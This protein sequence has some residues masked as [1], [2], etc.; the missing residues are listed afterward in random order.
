[1]LKL[2]YDECASNPCKHGA[3]CENKLTSYKCTC[4]P[5]YTGVNCEIEIDYCV[6]S[7]CI[8]GGS[9]HN[10]KTI[11]GWSCICPAAFGG[12]NCSIVIDQCHSNPCKN[13]ATCVDGDNAYTCQCLPGFTGVNCQT[14]INECENVTCKHGV[15]KDLVNKFECECNNNYF[16]KF[17]ET[18]IACP[19]IIPTVANSTTNITGYDLGDTVTYHCVSGYKFKDMAKNKTIKCDPTNKWIGLTSDMVCE[20][21]CSS[22]PRINYTDIDT[23]YTRFGTVANYTCK[24][25]Y[26]FP[27]NI[28]T[29]NTTC[30]LSGNWSRTEVDIPKC[31]VVKCPKLPNHS[32]QQKTNE[33]STDFNTTVVFWCDI[34]YTLHD[35][36]TARTIKCQENGKWTADLPPCEPVRCLDLGDIKNGQ[37]NSTATVYGSYIHYQCGKNSDNKQLRMLDGATYKIIKCDATWEWSDNVTDCELERCY[38]LPFVANA[39]PSDLN[40]TWGHS[41]ELTCDKGHSFSTTGIVSKKKTT[42]KQS[43]KWR[44]ILPSCVA[45]KCGE[46]M[47]VKNAKPDTDKRLYGTILTYNCIKGHEFGDKL[48]AKTIECIADKSWNRTTDQYLLQGCV[49]KKCT[50]PPQITNGTGPTDSN[51]RVYGDVLN[52]VCSSGFKFIDGE[53]KRNLLCDE[54]GNWNETDLSCRKDRCD[55]V[56]FFDNTITDTKNT[57][58]YTNVTYRCVEG[59]EWPINKSYHIIFCDNDGKWKHRSPQPLTHC[60]PK[61]CSAIYK[62]PNATVAGTSLVFNSQINYTCDTGFLFQPKNETM[63]TQRCDENA[64]WSPN[65]GKCESKQYSIITLSF[66]SYRVN[67]PAIYR[68]FFSLID[69]VLHIQKKCNFNVISFFLVIHCEALPP[70]ENTTTS[71]NETHYRTKALYN[72]LPG[73]QFKAKTKSFQV[74]CTEHGNWTALPE[75]CEVVFCPPV[76]QWGDMTFNSTSNEFNSVVAYECNDKY[77]FADLK[78]NPLKQRQSICNENKQ[79]VP[80]IEDCVELESIAAELKGKSYD[81]PQAVSIGT[82]A[83]I[84]L[85]I[86]IGLIILLDVNKMWEDL[87]MM[88]QNIE[89]LLKKR[90]NKISDS[91]TSLGENDKP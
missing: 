61:N 63:R 4:K 6:S 18:R 5:G 30:L 87:K 90:S 13:N 66:K 28:T 84:L 37:R 73:Y 8:N 35:N 54:S 47:K 19:K 40:A 65:I 29:V 38:P 1:M 64:Q 88:R 43:S 80:N 20:P 83:V 44:P 42:C 49:P 12:D 7:P 39:E 10:N 14:N 56:A 76:P 3:N 24:P 22:P 77:A 82:V 59:H 69:G 58:W 79:W 41:V 91:S 36:T 23:D 50:P 2:A 21:H 68:L 78:T 62:M 70:V 9:C 72:C 25:G 11:P 31:Q 32:H 45:V 33:N 81:S 15:C 17:C 71:T 86:T 46:P 51:Q 57:S 67:K 53:T 89:T 34:G 55:P 48:L 60:I 85:S 27:D 52:Y 16:G 75:P 74:E 26:H